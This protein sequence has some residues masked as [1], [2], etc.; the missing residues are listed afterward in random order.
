MIS[1]DNLFPTII[2]LTITAS[3]LVLHLCP[4]FAHT[5]NRSVSTVLQH[6]LFYQTGKCSA[7]Q[8]A[9]QDPLEHMDMNDFIINKCTSSGFI[10]RLAINKKGIV[11]SPEVFDILNKLSKSDE[12]NATGDVQLLCKLFSGEKCSYHY[13]TEESRVI[14]PNT[15]FCIL[16]STQ[17]FN[18]AKL[19]ARMDH[20][21]GLVD[22]IL[23]ATP[24]AFRPTLTEM[25]AASEQITT[26]VVSDFRELFLNISIIEDN[27]EFAF[28]DQGK[29]FL[30][31]TMD[32]FVE[33]VNEV[34]REGKVPPKSKTPELIPRLACALYVFNHIMGDLLASVS[35]TQPPTTISKATLESAASFVNHLESQKDILC[36]VNNY[37]IIYLH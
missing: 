29:E 35:A 1:F 21:H 37:S 24:L 33:E 17:L 22:R 11:L 9:A 3:V 6:V 13:S 32:Q 10:K 34:I 18:A 30:R 7:V 25:E 8:Y 14:P 28:D 5:T 16:G 23:L 12:D 15:P 4:P 26:E 2:T 20:G 36:Q 31:D 19:I 27:V